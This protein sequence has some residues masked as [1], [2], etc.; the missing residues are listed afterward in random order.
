[1][2]LATLTLT[3]LIA[4]SAFAQETSTASTTTTT[5]PSASE[6]TTTST[7][8]T[9]T[10]LAPEKERVETAEAAENRR[11]EVRNWFMAVLGD[12]PYDVSRVLKLDSTLLTNSE[13][14]AKYP[15]IQQFV[16]RHPE[17]RRNPRFYLSQLPP[18]GGNNSALDEIVEMLAVFGG[19]ALATFVVLW[20]IRTTIEQRRWNRLSRTQAEVHNKILDRFGSSEEVLAYMQSPAGT[21][22]LES[23]PIAVQAEPQAPA[24][25][26]PFARVLR[27]IQIGVVVAVAALGMMLTSIR[28]TGETEH[29][30]FGMGA[31]G[32]SVGAGFIAS[33]I[34]SIVMSRRLGL[35]QGPA[36]AP[37]DD[38]RSA[39]LVR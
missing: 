39:G 23:A 28:Y 19:F 22:F 25:P 32:F 29:G 35:W 37:D 7:T 17:I 18:V 20:L 4:S 15:D 21:K 5:N 14:L 9:G 8:T 33:A 11:F 1:L 6:A 24:Q 34:V 16:D 13:W 38:A 3:V 36:A 31:I 26:A 2:K 30:L 10:E 27:S 12:H